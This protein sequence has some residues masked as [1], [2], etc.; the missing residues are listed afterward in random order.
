M[1]GAFCDGG[2]DGGFEEIHRY[3]ASVGSS[4]IG[5]CLGSP[6]VRE[7][8]GQL[9][10][11]FVTG[12]EVENRK[13]PDNSRQARGITLYTQHSALSREDKLAPSAPPYRD[14]SFCLRP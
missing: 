4:G 14:N 1:P 3:G 2:R 8:G 11:A 7:R 9:P 13:G 5:D 10:G 6:G 12:M